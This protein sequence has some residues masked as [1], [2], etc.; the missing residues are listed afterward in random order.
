MPLT[1]EPASQRLKY[2]ENAYE[3]VREALQFT[4]ERLHRKRRTSE[5]DEL[6]VH[7]TG[8]ELLRGIRELALDQYGLLARIV[9]RRWGVRTTDDFGRIVFE[10]VERGEMRKTQRDRLSDFFDVYDFA[11]AFDLNYE[12]DTSKAFT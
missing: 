6:E 8:A 2:H 5:A 11:E 12:V 4:Q 9:F 1:R 3:F 7:I 10:L